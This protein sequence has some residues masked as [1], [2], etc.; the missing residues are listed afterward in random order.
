MGNRIL[1]IDLGT[2]NSCV[3]VVQDGR[4][5]VLGVDGRTTVPSCVGIQKGQEI[6]GHAAKRHAVT[7][8]ESTVTAVKR[9]LGH[10]HDSPEVAAAQKRMPLPIE[11]SPLGGVLL[12]VADKEYTPVQLSARILHKIREVAE[13]AL[14]ENTDKAVIS[15][16]AHFNDVQRRSTKLAAEYAGI[17][18][19]RLINEPTAAAFAYGYRKGEDCTLAVY[20]LGGGTFDITVM[21]A[22]GDCFEVIATDGDSYLGG[23]DLDAAVA[24]WLREEFQRQHDVDLAGDASAMRRLKEAAEQAKI[25]LS[26]VE[27]TSIEIPYLAQ[28]ADGTRPLFTSTLTR[29][30]LEELTKPLIDRTLEL[31]TEC[32]HDAGLERSDID[33][34]LLVGGQSRMTLVREAVQTFFGKEPRRDINPDEVVAMGAALYGYSLVAEELRQE[35][36]SAGD[37]A[38][39]VA[40]KDTCIARKI[41]SGMEDL[42]S[43]KLSDEAL[44]EKLSALL[45][46]TEGDGA[47]FGDEDQDLPATMD[48]LRDEICEL[49][50]KADSMMQ[51]LTDEFMDDLDLDDDTH[52]ETVRLTAEKLTG[53]LQT[54]A[55]ASEDAQLLFDEAEE[56]ASARKV[57]L[58]DVTSHALGIASVGNLFTILVERN[59]KVPTEDQRVFSTDR[60][61]QSE[62]EIRVYQGEAERATENQ[63]LGSFILEGI[64]PA[65]RMEPKI[66]VRFRVDEDGILSVHARDAN[67][68]AEQ[69]IR[70]EDPLGLQTQSTDKK[71]EES[72]DF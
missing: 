27:Q 10:G 3:A 42:T 51:Q 46:V 53:K 24:D 31:C 30:K 32:L 4:A 15:V 39:E 65:T 8:P 20:D 62:V 2:L 44:A 34:I 60:D 68:G 11:P 54:A 69:S 63:L 6:V 58:I 22:T 71:G 28:I 16:P 18:V 49:T 48:Q 45:A 70:I 36:E 19:L 26:D 23:E 38:F 25:E 17:E 33:E 1:G 57:K 43:T 52:A 7:E 40:L 64:A 56:H 59:A 72:I 37:E 29:E 55:A 9:L 50:D 47:F 66:D 5:V 41:V 61:N 12:R 21:T 14:G 35:A 67:S 13:E